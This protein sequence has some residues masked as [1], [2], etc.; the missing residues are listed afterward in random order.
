[1]TSHALFEQVFGE[2]VAL[3]RSQ[4]PDNAAQDQA[5]A[6]A[7]GLV[8]TRLVELDAGVEV[9]GETDPSSLKAR[10]LAR[11]VDTIRILP[12]ADPAELLY[13]AQALAHDAAPVASS[14]HVDV[15]L[16]PEIV[17]GRPG[18]ALMPPSPEF[19]PT[20]SGDE[21]RHRA[22]RR[23]LLAGARYRGPERRKGDRR[24]RGERRVQLV[25]HQ[26]G[27]MGRFQGLLREA[28]AAGEWP[29]AL[30]ALAAIMETL[31][32]IPD[33]DRRG[34]SIATRRL[35]T[36]ETIE[37][38]VELAVKDPVQAPRAARVLRWIGPDAADA[39]LAALMAHETVGP[40]RVLYEV[41]GG[42]PEAFPV[43]LP[44]L[45]RGRWHEARHAA[46][47]LGRLGNPEA[48][49]ALRRRIADPDE[50]VRTA[51][52]QALAEFP[53]AEVADALRQAL[54]SPSPKTRI[55]AA[56]AI[57]RR[58]A[59]A[60][61]MPLR[62]LLEQE[63]DP[64]AWRAVARALG[65]LQT[66]DAAAALSAIALQKRSL[67]GGGFGPEQRVEAVRALAL[68][69]G[70]VAR[71]ALERLGREGDGPVRGE[72]QRRLRDRAQQAV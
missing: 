42:M 63:R 51:V 38:V 2:L 57:A 60:F 65:L 37:R 61:A 62:N 67:L 39:M 44:Y 55:V 41:L 21:R 56:D 11:R 64:D 59:V 26:A 45:Q 69:D 31:P 66:P 29:K 13:L 36:P 15:A 28:I 23:Q 1:V 47:L 30:H 49:D 71:A 6:T 7:T 46:E 33:Q 18:L 8:A 24:R 27:D 22:D 5:L 72:A 20:R 32:G 54:A 53:I 35:L 14:A 4:S 52:V 16:V 40:R 12:G 19:A 43:T 70:P 68:A 17:P 9:L 25:R 48:I 58:R 10:L 50:R 34:H 3:L